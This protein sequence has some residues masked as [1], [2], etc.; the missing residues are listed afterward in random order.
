LYGSEFFRVSDLVM[1]GSNNTLRLE[2]QEGRSERML[3]LQRR[4]KTFYRQQTTIALVAHM[5]RLCGYA[6]TLYE[7]SPKS[8]SI[9][10]NATRIATA[11]VFEHFEINPER[12]SIRYPVSTNPYKYVERILPH[13][14]HWEQSDTLLAAAKYRLAYPAHILKQASDQRIWLPAT[15]AD[16]I[17]WQTGFAAI[18]P[19]FSIPAY[20]PGV[21]AQLPV[22]PF[23]DDSQPTSGV[24]LRLPSAPPADEFY[25]PEGTLP[26]GMT[27]AQTQEVASHALNS[28]FV[29]WADF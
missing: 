29:D 20:T 15:L 3:S 24:A 1:S 4:T 9:K 19:D 7:A 6:I 28:F 17:A 11:N 10:V 18:H 26:V 5:L 8:R 21:I 12:G 22:S 14:I 2:A 16:V 27:V 23:R 13:G 25:E